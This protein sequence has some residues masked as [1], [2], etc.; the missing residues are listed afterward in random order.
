MTDLEI[1]TLTLD[2]S[3]PAWQRIQLRYPDTPDWAT[4]DEETLVRLVENFESEPSC[5]TS[6][7]LYLGER[8]PAESRRLANWL[9]AHPAAD[10]WLKAAARDAL[11]Q[12]EDDPPGR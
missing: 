4:L 12:L 6:A 1:R 9:L 11:E 2:P 10:Q 8:N 7:I 5:A 3:L